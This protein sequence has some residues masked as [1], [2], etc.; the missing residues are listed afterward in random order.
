MS[1]NISYEQER[2]MPRAVIFDKCRIEVSTAEKGVI[3]KRIY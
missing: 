2:G 1:G 3:K